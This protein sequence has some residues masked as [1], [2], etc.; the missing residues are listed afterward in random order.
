MFINQFLLGVFSRNYSYFKIGM[1]ESK[2]K[3]INVVEKMKEA[4]RIS[5]FER[6]LIHGRIIEEYE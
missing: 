6:Q 5:I 1:K 4:H 3:F 2:I